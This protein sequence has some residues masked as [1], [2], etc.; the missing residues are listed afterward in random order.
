MS[1]FDK[2]NAISIF[3]GRKNNNMIKFSLEN[4]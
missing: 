2:N 3:I 1:Y 4:K